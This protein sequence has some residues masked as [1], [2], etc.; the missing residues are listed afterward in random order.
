MSVIPLMMDDM[1]QFRHSLFDQNFGHGILHGLAH[2]TPR[3][4][5]V[6]PLN[7]G[8]YHPLP[9]QR[10]TVCKI[11]DD[12][13]CF[14]VNLDV[15]QFSP[16]E[17][18]VKMVDDFIVIEAKHEE[19]Q[20]EHGFI[21]RQFQRRYKLPSAVRLD[22]LKSNLSSDGILT[23]TASLKPMPLLA[24]R[25]RIIPIVLTNAPAVREHVHK[26]EKKE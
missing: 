4:S 22:T 9:Y 12:K 23:V 5:A 25:E 14:K 7:F 24:A 16:E 10:N 3:R 6:G 13:D 8:Y 11:E 19:R 17:I 15:Q 21:S 1:R 26:D 18:T 20:D 2:A